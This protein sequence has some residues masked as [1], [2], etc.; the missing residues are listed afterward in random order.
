MSHPAD[1]LY[2]TPSAPLTGESE[3]GHAAALPLTWGRVIRVWWAYYWPVTLV[4][5]VIGLCAGTLAGVVLAATHS[6]LN[7]SMVAASLGG[8]LAVPLSVIFVRRS[9][10][11]S[12]REFKIQLVDRGA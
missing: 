9:L 10:E 8:I 11:K 12:Y 7:P 1:H 6:K 5:G 3:H 4:G 2:R